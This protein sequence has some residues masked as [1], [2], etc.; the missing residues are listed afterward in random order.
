MIGI[1]E[2]LGRGVL[3]VMP[4][5]VR[6]WVRS[7]RRRR[8]HARNTQLTAAEVFSETY[9]RGRWGGRPGEFYSG[10]GSDERNIGRYCA[11]IVE[12]AARLPGRPTIVD[13]GCGDFRVGRRIA[14]P[15]VDY[16]GVDVVPELVARNQT[17]F[18]SDRVRFL[19][20]DIASDALP[21]GDICLLREVL[22][23]LSNGQ[24]LR[25]LEQ[26]RQYERVFI[27]EHTA[28]DPRAVPN[29][30]KPH[31]ATVRAVEG[32]A[33]FLDREPFNVEGLVEVLAT[34]HALGGTLRTFLLHRPS[35]SGRRSRPRADGKP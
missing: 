23:H 32:S 1:A 30:D 24:I 17:L 6:A 34:E 7:A 8:Y 26:V 20:A 27:T 14:S 12:T 4:R 35:G 15:N 33:L 22:Q 28:D 18:G 9:A 13:L 21:E 16:V 5:P 3:R 31:G 11:L 10:S 2:D 19:C 25:V 29:L